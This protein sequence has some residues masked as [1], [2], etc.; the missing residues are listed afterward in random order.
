MSY[1]DIIIHNNVA[2]QFLLEVTVVEPLN[3]IVENLK[4]ITHYKSDKDVTFLNDNLDF[5][6][7]LAM[8]F[9]GIKLNIS[10]AQ[11]KQLRFTTMNDHNRKKML[12]YFELL[13]KYFNQY[14]ES[15]K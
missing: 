1:Q 12:G 6:I 4:K 7:D 2:S 8:E 5:Y 13:L 3:Q 11:R 10:K 15:I 14:V 9:I